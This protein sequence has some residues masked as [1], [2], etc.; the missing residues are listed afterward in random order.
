MSEQFIGPRKV[1]SVIESKEKTPKGAEMVSVLF[2]GGYVE[3]MPK[4]NFDLLVKS[5]A[6]DYNDLI[7]IKLQPALEEVLNVILE[8]NLDMQEAKIMLK[9]V[10]DEINNNFN[11]AINFKFTGDDAKF[12]PGIDP[13]ENI[14]FLEA[15]KILQQIPKKDGSK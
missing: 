9:S 3:L 13:M 1:D 14:P 8:Y 7:K 4:K 5:E 15:Y 11:R 12:I 10:G 2:E 6:S